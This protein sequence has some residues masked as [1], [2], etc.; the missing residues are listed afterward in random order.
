M[1]GAGFVSDCLCNFEHMESLVKRLA[2]LQNTKHHVKQ[3]PHRSAD[4]HHLGFAGTFNPRVKGDYDGVVAL[5][6][7]SWHI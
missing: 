5:R 7:D 4:G 3:L 6:R 2:R 1:A